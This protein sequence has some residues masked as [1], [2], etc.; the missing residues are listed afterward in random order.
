MPYKKSGT[1]M[2]NVILR[3]NWNNNIIHE[4]EWRHSMN[5]SPNTGSPVLRPAGHRA[6]HKGNMGVHY[7]ACEKKYLFIDLS[8]LIESIWL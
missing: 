6:G 3:I 5:V 8:E 7:T 4:N 1:F 2:L